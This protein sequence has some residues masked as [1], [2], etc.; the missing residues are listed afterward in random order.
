MNVTFHLFGSKAD[1]LRF[2]EVMNKI[3]ERGRL[4]NFTI[5]PKSLYFRDG[6]RL[7][8]LVSF[9]VKKH[10]YIIIITMQFF[11]LVCFKQT[12]VQLEIV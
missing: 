2:E 11:R 4:G 6:A 9:K 10:V 3:V 8:I 5:V 12:I 1:G 7:R